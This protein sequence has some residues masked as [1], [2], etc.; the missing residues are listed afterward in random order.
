MVMAWTLVWTGANERAKLNDM[1][2]AM[3]MTSMSEAM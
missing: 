3:A 1:A 2:H